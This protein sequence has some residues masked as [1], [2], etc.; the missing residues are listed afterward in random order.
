MSRSKSGSS[1]ESQR[2][3]SDLISSSQRKERR[4]AGGSSGE[5]DMLRDEIEELKAEL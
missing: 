1:D 3:E 5:V 4:S 2:D